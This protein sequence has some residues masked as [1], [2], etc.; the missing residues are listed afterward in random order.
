M[1]E[2]PSTLQEGMKED[3]PDVKINALRMKDK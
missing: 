2:K 1:K 3:F